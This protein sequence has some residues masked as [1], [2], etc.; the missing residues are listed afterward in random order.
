MY[1]SYVNSNYKHSTIDI[2]IRV[3][4]KG[5]AKIHAYG[6]RILLNTEWTFL[7]NIQYYCTVVTVISI[8]YYQTF[9]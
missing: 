1:F 2:S 6:F 8:H 7:I 3:V 5:P 4:S 9:S